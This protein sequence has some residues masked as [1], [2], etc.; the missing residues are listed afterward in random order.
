MIKKIKNILRIIFF[1]LARYW[2]YL[3]RY[4]RVKPDS[5]TVVLTNRCN[6]KCMMCNYWQNKE[7]E[8]LGLTDIIRV[9]K[10]AKEAGVKAV[11]L[12]GG[13][14]LIRKD[15]FEIVRLA[16]ENGFKVGIITNALLLDER[17]AGQIAESGTDSVTISMDAGEGLNDEI[18]GVTGAFEKSLKAIF[19]LKAATEMRKKQLD[20][21]LGSLIMSKTLGKNGLFE[22]VRLCEALGVSLSPRLIDKN[23]SYFAGTKS[24]S[25]FVA[26]EEIGRL[27]EVVDKLLAAKK[28]APQALPLSLASI[29]FIKKY[30]RDPLSRDIPC[31][32]GVLGESWLNANG[33]LH[34]CA[35]LPSVGNIKERSFNEIVS[36]REWKNYATKMFRK[37]CPGCSCNYSS[38]VESSFGFILS[39]IIEKIF[40]PPLDAEQKGMAYYYLA[41]PV[42]VALNMARYQFAQKYVSGKK[43]LDLGCGARKGPLI[44][45]EKAVEVTGADISRE[46]IEFNKKIFSAPNVKYEVMDAEKLSFTDASF[47]A[48]VSFEVI[49]HLI[50]PEKYLEGIRRVLSSGGVAVF[51]TPNINRFNGDSQVI[52]GHIK[53]YTKEDLKS[54]LEKYFSSVEVYGIIE[55]EKVTNVV[56]NEVSVN[57]VIDYDPL[58]LRRII[59]SVLRKK[60]FSGLVKIKARLTGSP[61]ASEVSKNDYGIAGYNDIGKAET[62]LAVVIK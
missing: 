27:D 14:P 33:D 29:R 18:R 49:E 52:R 57:K 35:V 17:M 20:I 34:N 61:A 8:D 41:D 45:A 40:Y 23:I 6:S 48:V 31:L 19:Y 12:Y 24:E 26:K 46:A 50:S 13:E 62:L 47:D 56:K 1:S 53:E 11:T 39:K 28:R 15:I 32:R 16:K 5:L 55:Y 60:I 36:S 2:P 21:Q 54:L 44:L 7:T 42:K 59:P 3:L 43:V 51:S 22:V 4:Y 30:F 10:E 37:D 38:N 58:R 25:L 9:F